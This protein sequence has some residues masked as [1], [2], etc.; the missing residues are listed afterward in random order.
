MRTHVGVFILAS[1]LGYLPSVGAQE[2]VPKGEEISDFQTKHEMA[3]SLSYQKESL[4]DAA[5]LYAEL[6]RSA[7]TRNDIARE[8]IAVLERLGRLDEVIGRLRGLV[9]REEDSSVLPQLGE[10]LLL[11][12][13][14]REVKELLEPY[15]K[16]NRNDN[17]ARLTLARAY[18]WSG[19]WKRAKPHYEKAQGVKARELADLYLA[20]GDMEK[21]VGHLGKAAAFDPRL[22]RRYALL[23]ESLQRDSEATP[24]LNRILSLE[25]DE[26]LR[27]R[28]RIALRAKEP[29]AALELLERASATPE[30]L[31]DR[32][33]ILSDMGEVAQAD[34]LFKRALESN[35]GKDNLLRY[36]D[37]LT[38]WGD[39]YRAEAVYR[40]ML[41]DSRDFDVERRLGRVLI[42][43]ERF[44]EARGI[45]REL[46]VDGKDTRLE[47]AESYLLEKDFQKALEIVTPLVTEDDRARLILARVLLEAR[48]YEPIPELLRGTSHR[49]ISIIAHHRSGRRE[50][51]LRLLGQLT[52][53]TEAKAL[54]KFLQGNLDP[55]EDLEVMFA[56]AQ[57]LSAEGKKAEALVLLKE[58]YRR[59]ADDFYVKL[60]LAE[61]LGASREYDESVKL[62][63][64]LRSEA[65]TNRKVLVGMARVLSWAKRYDDS[66]ELYEKIHTAAPADATVQMERARVAFWGKDRDRGSQYYTE[67]FEEPLIEEDDEESPYQRYE[68]AWRTVGYDPVK[69]KGLLRLYPRYREQKR[70]YWELRSKE[71]LWDKHFVRAT[72]AHEEVLDFDPTN[73]E[74]LFDE[75]QAY[76][77]LGL[78]NCASSSYLDLLEISPLHSI[79]QEALR[80]EKRKGQVQLGGSLQYWREKGRGGLSDLTRS[81]STISLEAPVDRRHL[82][83]ARIGAMNEKPGFIDNTIRSQLYTLGVDLRL[84]RALSIGGSY[85]RKEYESDRYEGTNTG[86]L[87]VQGSLNDIALLTAGYERH[88]EIYNY[89]SVRDRIQ[90]DE[91]FVKGVSHLTRALTLE[92]EVRHHRFNDD[93]EI[94]RQ[95]VALGYAF[96]D[97]PRIFKVTLA[98]QRRDAE[99]ESIYRQEGEVLTEIIHPYWAPKDALIH[100]LTLEWY[101]DLSKQF[102][103]GHE[104]H[105]YDLKLT[106]YG[107]NKENEG[108]ELAGEWRYEFQDHWTAKVEAGISRSQLWDGSFGALSL[109]YRF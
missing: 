84:S 91:L 92:G 45:F 35:K 41:K 8:Y 49:E 59:D 105:Y 33:S 88:N 46:L 93:N 43:S 6:I 65:P 75:G 20:V 90:S 12:K 10:A 61:L 96:T 67:I 104:L 18:G 36:A 95:R 79:A 60:A 106:F 74:V 14:Y 56:T 13:R 21:G 58:A 17:S 37:H 108:G 99:K 1:M 53:E 68:E 101:H 3:K 71:E 4:S 83:Y 66:L 73:Q 40:D 2:I 42:A 76:C 26:V 31:L 82:L 89:F 44:E 9:G 64:E 87:Y 16:E 80:R 94:D 57:L 100:S 97:H 70:A 107:D 86:Q 50:E 30:V 78:G 15:L 51:A 81:S 69:G 48:R 5:S 25:D 32:A 39:F 34:R 23:L 27:A 38:R 28:A 52:G 109:M 22:R 55:E 103:C 85:T 77:A 62:Y 29:E 19:D 7:P 11:K 54:E 98:E 63:E 24:L 47:I 102:Y 72:K